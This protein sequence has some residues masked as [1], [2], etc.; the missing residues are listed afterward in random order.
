MTLKQIQKDKQFLICY[1]IFETSSISFFIPIVL[2]KKP[3]I[4]F[5]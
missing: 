1:D 4:H 2:D 3:K 5:L